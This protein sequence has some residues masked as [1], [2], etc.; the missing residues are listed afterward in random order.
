MYASHIL[1]LLLP[2]AFAIMTPKKNFSEIAQNMIDITTENRTGDQH[3]DMACSCLEDIISHQFYSGRTDDYPQLLTVLFGETYTDATYYIQQK[4]LKTINNESNW[5]FIELCQ[6]PIDVHEFFS[7]EECYEETCKRRMVENH[8]TAFY[9]VILDKYNESEFIDIVLHIKYANTT[10]P[11]AYILVYVEN[12]DDYLVTA[13]EVL[14]ELML[15]FLPYTA[16]LLPGSNNDFYIVKMNITTIGPADCGSNK[17][18]YVIDQCIDGKMRHIKKRYFNVGLGRNMYNC[19]LGVRAKEFQPFVINEGEG[20]EIELL[21]IIGQKLNI[22]FNITL[23]NSS[24]WGDVLN[25]EWTGDLEDIFIN[26]YLGIGNVD[27]GMGYDRDFDYSEIYHMEPRV[28]VVPKA[29]L[30][31]KW[32][33]FIAMFNLEIWGVCFGALLFYALMFY[34]TAKVSETVSAYKKIDTSLEASFKVMLSTSEFQPKSDL[35]R[36]FFVSLAVF[37]IVLYAIYTVY[38]LKYLKNPIREHQYTENS[39]IYDSFGNLRVGV[40][41]LQRLKSL[42]NVSEPQVKKIYDAYQEADDENDTVLYWINKVAEERNIWTISSRLYAEYL[43]A[44]SDVATDTDGDPKVFIFKRQ[45]MTYYVSI[46]ARQGHP[47]LKKI[48]RVIGQLTQGAIMEHLV[49]NQTVLIELKNAKNDKEGVKQFSALSM[50]H[51]QGTFALLALGY[52]FGFITLILEFIVDEV[53]ILKLRKQYG[54]LP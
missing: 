47:L 25:D 39:E 7:Y 15:F 34:L 32:R 46:L 53:A 41:G 22:H 6:S 36:L 2:F 28:W 27:P 45:L 1:Y 51:L 33:A 50:D 14:E 8:N 23:S 43:L 35:T 37:G 5:R 10:N 16:V 30:V 12:V 38:L 18:I 20:F 19:T 42:F 49:Y 44:H 4:T 48:N 24:G 26:M 21:R 54:Y 52:I 13:K 3:V 31:P 40:G 9:L 29:R 11:A 17:N